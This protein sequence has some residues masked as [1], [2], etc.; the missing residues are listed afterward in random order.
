MRFYKG[1]NMDLA[2][3]LAAKEKAL[4][5]IVIQANALTDQKQQLIQESLML[6]GDIRTIKE[7]MKET[8]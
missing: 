4:R 6:S 2:G 5:D 1:G 3:K 7:L 8:K